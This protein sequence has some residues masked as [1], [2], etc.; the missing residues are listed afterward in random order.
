MPGN[1]FSGVQIH[2]DTKV[3][4]LAARSDVSNIAN[5]YE[6]GGF[7]VKVLVQM[8]EAVCV[9]R[10]SAGNR[11]LVGGHFGQLQLSHQPVHPSDTDA[12]AIVML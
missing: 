9:F 6:V 11:G 5:P 2:Y 1:D 8:I 3:I 10:M 12:Y 4:P 7:L